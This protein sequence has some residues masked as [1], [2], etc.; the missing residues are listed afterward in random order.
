MGKYVGLFCCQRS[1]FKPAP[2]QA[3]SVSRRFFF[4][5]FTLL[6]YEKNMRIMGLK[7]QSIC[8]I[9]VGWG[10]SWR[11]ARKARTSP[12]FR[13]SGCRGGFGG[14]L[15][16]ISMELANRFPNFLSFPPDS[17]LHPEF[18]N[19][20]CGFILYHRKEFQYFRCLQSSR[21]LGMSSENSTRLLVACGAGL[22][23]DGCK[24]N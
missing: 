18:G 10:C 19:I 22:L 11:I 1:S 21:V 3:G 6:R 14:R 9:P 16:R 15:R 23:V 4:S 12:T 8:L 2:G 13:G 24:R 20:S 7:G 5:L 17:V